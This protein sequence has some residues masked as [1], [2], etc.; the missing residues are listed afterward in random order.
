MDASNYCQP[1]DK[2]SIN[3]VNVTKHYNGRAIL[4]DVAVS[5]DF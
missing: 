4:S 5:S 1:F 3:C 2:C